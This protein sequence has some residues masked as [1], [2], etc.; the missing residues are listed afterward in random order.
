MI[1]G[2]DYFHLGYK[3]AV[4][5]GMVAATIPNQQQIAVVKW[6]DADRTWT[7]NQILTTG[8]PTSPGEITALDTIT[9]GGKKQ[10]VYV[11][12]NHLY[13]QAATGNTTAKDLGIVGTSQAMAV[14]DINM[15]EIADI[16]V[17][18]YNQNLHVFIL[19]ALGNVK[20]SQT[21]KINAKPRDITI[22]DWDGDK[23]NDILI[24][25]GGSGL[26]IKLNQLKPVAPTTPIP[27]LLHTKF[28]YTYVP[29]A[30]GI[31]TDRIATKIQTDIIDQSIG[32]IRKTTSTFDN[33][34]GNLT[35]IKV[36]GTDT[37]TTA[38]TNTHY[39][40]DGTI[41]WIKDANNNWTQYNYFGSSL[42]GESKQVQTILRG[43]L[44]ADVTTESYK[45]NDSGYVKEFKDG[46]GNTT[47]YQYDDLNRV[48]KVTKSVTTLDPITSLPATT[49]NITKTEYYKTGWVKSVTDA[50]TH[51]TKFEYDGVGRITKKTTADG[52]VTEYEYNDIRELELVTL[53]S[54]SNDVLSK[55]RYEYDDVH[56]LSSVKD[57]LS[58]SSLATETTYTYSPYGI[59]PTPSITTTV[60]GGGKT[61]VTSDKYDR[62]Q[63]LIA[64]TNPIGTTTSNE[65][66]DDGQIK[67][68]KVA[69]RNSFGTIETH[70]TGFKYDPLGRQNQ[71][72]DAL[73][74]STLMSYDLVGNM[75][76]MTDANGRITT[77]AY[78]SLNRKTQTTTPVTLYDIDTD[79][80]ITSNLTTEYTYDKNSNVS[81][82]KDPNGRI[83]NNTYDEL[84]RRATTTNAFGTID[85]ATAQSGYDEVGN[86]TVAID[87]N[88]HTTKYGYDKVNRQNKT[89]DALGKVTSQKTYDAAGR[90][91]SSTNM[92]GETTAS[93]Y[94]DVTHL[95]TMVNS[96]GT[97]TQKTD[98]YG[99]IIETTDAVGR[100]NTYKYD[101][102]NRKVE[103][104]DYRGGETFDSYDGFNNLI[105]R[106]DASNN[107]T[108]YEYDAL[109]RRTNTK[110]SI[111]QISRVEYDNVGNKIDEYL[112]VNDGIERH[113]KYVYDQLNRQYSMTSAVGT[114]AA[115]TMQQGYDKVGNV[116][117]TKDALGR[118]TTSTYDNLNR[119]TAVTQAFGT[120]D[121][122]TTAYTYDKVGNRLSEK[123]GRGYTT[124]YQ[125]DE[126]NRQIQILDPYNNQTQTKYFDTSALVGTVLAEL[127]GF[128]SPSVSTIT[129]KVIKT[130]DA[131]GNAQYV[132][133]DKF[134]RQIETYDAT[135][136]R[137]S[138]SLYDAVDRV[139]KSTDTFG[140]ITTTSYALDNLHQTTTT[141]KGVTL[142]STFDSAGRL[143]QADETVSGVTRTTKSDYDKRNRKTK[144]TDAV[145]GVTNYVY[146]KDNQTASVQDAVGNLTEYFY[147]PAG[148]LNEERSPL[149]SRF[150]KYDLVNNRIQGT[151]RNGRVTR[152]D[153]DNLNR[154]K[155]ELWMGNGKQFAYTYDEN[156]N[157]ISV[158][159]GNIR[160]EYGY[161]Y[162]DLL[163][164]VDRIKAGTPTVSFEYGYDEIGN[165]TKADELVDGV[166]KARTSYEYVDPR[167]LN[168]KITQTGVGLANKDVKFTYDAAGLNTKVERY[169][170]GLLKVTTTNAFDAF[171]RLTGISQSNGGG[172][173][174]SDS[175]VLDDLS[176]LQAQTRDGV[177]RAIGYDDTDQV[178]G[179]SGGSNE[180]Y[181]YD[182]NGNRTNAGYVTDP[183]NQLRSDGTYNYEYDP[184]G[185]R[186][187]RTKISDNTVDEYRWDYRNRLTEIVSK[188]AGGGVIKTVDYEYD[189]DDQRVKKTV[190]SASLSAGDGVVENYYL[191]RDQIAFVTDGSGDRTFH[192]LYGLN[193][194]AVMA[195]DTPGG[196]VWS[197]ADRLG[198]IDLLTDK[199]GNV[200]DKRTFDSFGRVLS[201]TNPSVSFRYGYTGRERDLESG[202]D[203]YRA[204]YYDSNVGRF[205]SVDP[206]G[207]GAGDT[208]LYRYVSNNA[209]NYTDPSGEILP[210]LAA[211][212]AAGLIGAEIGAV[213]GGVTGFAKSLANSYD[214]GDSLSLNTIGTALGE[215]AKGAAV[216]AASGFAI[217]GT[218]GATAVASPF[219]AAAAGVG[220]AAYG[221]YNSANSAVDNFQNGR[222]ASGIVDTATGLL[223]VFGLHQGVSH[224]VS[225]FKSAAGS[226]KWRNTSSEWDRVAWDSVR[227]YEQNG[228]GLTQSAITQVRQRT[229]GYEM[230]EM[231]PNGLNAGMGPGAASR[232]EFGSN[233]GGRV[234][235]EIPDPWLSPVNSP[236][237]ANP[238]GS[239]DPH[240]T[241][242][243]VPDSMRLLPSGVG[244]RYIFPVAKRIS[245][246]HSINTITPKTRFGGGNQN[247]LKTVA[248]GHVNLSIDQAEI[249]LGLSFKLKNSSDILTSSGRVY[250]WHPDRPTEPGIYPTG[251]SF[252]TGNFNQVDFVAL[253]QAEF[254]L[255][256]QMVRDG[257]LQGQALRAYEGM[258]RTN[259]LGITTDSKQKLINLYNSRK[260]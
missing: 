61:R 246:A 133:S 96:L 207:F 44:T 62:Y 185:N 163:E 256:P 45:Y 100:I 67:F 148:R 10:L 180:A 248:Y 93:T 2:I 170:D 198:S 216:G 19:D 190:T 203:Y 59:N 220:L 88:N 13:L 7:V 253:T 84:N 177:G 60:T 72:V 125:Y 146:T 196:M 138:A 113:N 118:I 32:S 231:M 129:T 99:N 257:G 209:T 73:D 213:Y 23:Y 4:L 254:S 92:Y 128:I 105:A 112:T 102:L 39:N 11:A 199:D 218:L 208:N 224:G 176:R 252:S 172:V 31:E 76:S 63:R 214:N 159:D 255:L 127:T 12:G 137:T 139:I 116:V 43:Y 117:G 50:N 162:T 78:D 3:I 201:E 103:S 158:Y 122:T 123:S 114:T 110:D 26:D 107:V 211:F 75:T 145:G 229:L 77:N 41:D 150:Y 182:K 33:T 200:V 227:G 104:K 258:I 27:P 28:D 65:Y 233:S 156:S 144:V 90:V 202:L 70:T 131:K 68:S 242:S 140:K 195:Q 20:S 179:V 142:L 221:L 111:G 247:T 38:E 42:T 126:L 22:F 51:A 230:G 206:M 152:Y 80:P 259:N 87:A 181:A 94:D 225:T 36:V 166:L 35:N 204:R 244:E 34:T 136:H 167:Y 243:N 83:T 232:G 191:D 157:L 155:S 187:R 193:V 108:K 49:P 222:T 239:F 8:D 240:P 48:T 97:S 52:G 151:D 54:S 74:K 40:S 189:V 121:A 46:N 226:G 188:D 82:I 237:R 55:T 130:I 37:S 21:S 165:L 106:K 47:Y 53:K 101:K 171:G 197:L 58:A 9:I 192:Y 64:S 24:A 173:I 18:D 86:L 120:A 241:P 1:P 251:K 154:V 183:D 186:T 57:A 132:L 249:N 16:A 30:N 14:G 29:D 95:M 175:Y 164:K 147:D 210:F 115:A 149:G 15:D 81:S 212:L 250:G 223:D 234:F 91:I 219:L 245:S 168:T 71:V 235:D 215:G 17:A 119:Q 169:V 135:K 6:V 56:R 124:E 194:D 178:V 141:P 5:D 69:G 217:G 89:I 143:T 153:Y 85:A 184:E 134:D 205:I 161:D 236:V 174:A 66:F 238:A 79:A 98:A 160:Y 260:G 228:S 109:N 25:D